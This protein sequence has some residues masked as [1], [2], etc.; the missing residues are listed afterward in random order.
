M[1]SGGASWSAL[2]AQPSGD[3]P[4]GDGL[5]QSAAAPGDRGSHCAPYSGRRVEVGDESEDGLLNTPSNTTAD[6]GGDWGGNGTGEDSDSDV[7]F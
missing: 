5:H 1:T 4:P 3:A 6:R 2:I 7:L